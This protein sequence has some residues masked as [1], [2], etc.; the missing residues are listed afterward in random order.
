MNSVTVRLSKP[1]FDRLQQAA[2]R[3]R[4]SVDDYASEMCETMA[5]ASP[6]EFFV[7]LEGCRGLWMKRSVPTPSRERNG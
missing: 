4:R 1:A 2:R 5:T 7:P 3:S 6:G